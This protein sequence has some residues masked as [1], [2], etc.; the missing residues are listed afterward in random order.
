MPKRAMKASELGAKEAAASAEKPGLIVPLHRRVST[1]V[2]ALG[3]A[4]AVVV[5]FKVW[6]SR[7]TEHV[8]TVPKPDEVSAAAAAQASMLLDEALASCQMGRPQ[9]C[10]LD[11]EEAVR[12]DP[13]SVRDPRAVEI[14]ALIQMRIWGR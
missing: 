7:A 14:G 5:V 3:I 2:T 10:K 8:V 4:A 9:R 1:W 11:L 13:R 6:Q 12:L